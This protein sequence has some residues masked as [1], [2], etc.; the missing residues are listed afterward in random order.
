MQVVVVVVSLGYHNAEFPGKCNRIMINHDTSHSSQ[1]IVIVIVIIIM[2]DNV[3]DNVN[4][5]DINNT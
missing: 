5:N 4:D 2:S 3:N 1:D